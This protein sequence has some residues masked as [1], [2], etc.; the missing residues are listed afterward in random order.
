MSEMQTRKVIGL[1]LV[2]FFAGLFLASEADGWQQPKHRVEHLLIPMPPHKPI[3]P[4]VRT[5][6]LDHSVN[7]QAALEASRYA[8]KGTKP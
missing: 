1:T 5:L 3:V 8:V 4:S 6:T 7:M 2:I